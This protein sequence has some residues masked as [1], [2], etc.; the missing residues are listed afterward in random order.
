MWL[1]PHVTDEETVAQ[2][3]RVTC[4]GSRCQYADEPGFESM[5]TGS[6]ACILLLFSY[7]T[8]RGIC[9][10]GSEGQLHTQWV[11]VLMAVGT[12]HGCM[13]GG[14]GLSWKCLSDTP[15]YVFYISFP[16]PLCLPCQGQKHLC[17]SFSKCI[18]FIYICEAPIPR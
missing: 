15:G 4:L 1:P 9:P 10:W 3:R 7:Q 16:H 11:L 13:A 6:Q 14:G 2:K 18:N 12:F 5:Q 17:L 8:W